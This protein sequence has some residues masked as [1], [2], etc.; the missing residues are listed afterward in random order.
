MNP[1]GERWRALVAAAGRGKN[2]AQYSGDA[3][4]PVSRYRAAEFQQNLHLAYSGLIVG[5][6]PVA[7]DAIG[8]L[9][10]AAKRKLHFGQEST[11]SPPP[12]PGTAGAVRE[13]PPKDF[14]LLSGPTGRTYPP[15]PDTP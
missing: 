12:L 11:I 2:A 3:A 14:D 4:P 10:I 13:N 8:A 6:D 9:V 1:R 15:S 5:V 7:V